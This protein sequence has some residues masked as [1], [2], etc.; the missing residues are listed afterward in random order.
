MLSI[1]AQRICCFM[2]SNHNRS[3][4][5]IIYVII[6]MKKKM[7]QR[8]ITTTRTKINQDRDRRAISILIEFSK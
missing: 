7:L 6:F 4:F 2:N 3:I 5:K 1:S 8:E